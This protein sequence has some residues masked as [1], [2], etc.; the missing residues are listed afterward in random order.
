[1]YSFLSF[2]KKKKMSID[3]YIPL[4]PLTNPFHQ[5]CQQL[6]H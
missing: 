4:L 5:K 3:D 1:M 6:M 2:K